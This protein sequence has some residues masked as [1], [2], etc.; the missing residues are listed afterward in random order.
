MIYQEPARWSYTFQTYSCMTRLKAQLEPLPEKLLKSQDPVQIFERSVYSDRYVFAKNQFEIGHL[1]EIEWTI[2][3]D[4]HTFLVQEF[5]DRIALHGFLYLQASPEKCL[6][7]LHRR[8]RA[9]EKDIRLEYLEQLHAQHENWLVNKSTEVHF[10]NLRNAPVLVL[11]VNQ[12]FEHN[13][14][15]QEELMRKV[16]TFIKKL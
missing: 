15:V 10:E 6:E 5:G 11:D 7:R 12:D 2:Y 13:P 4:W 16:K 14:S 3:Q 9:E 8:A 1:G